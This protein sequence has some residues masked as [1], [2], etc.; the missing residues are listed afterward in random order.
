MINGDRL[1]ETFKTL[2]GIDSISKEEGALCRWLQQRLQELGFHTAVDQ[3]GSK[4]GGNTGNLIAHWRGNRAAAPLLLSAHM[5]T[6]EPGRGV[7]VQFKEGVFTSAGDTILGAD[8]K[9]ALAVMLEAISC[10]QENHIP[11]GPLELVITICEE[12]GLLGAKHLDYGQITARMGY[13]LDTRNPQAI[14]TRAPSSNRFEFRIHGKA[15]HAGAAPERGINAIALASKAIAQLNL[16]RI[17]SETTCNIGLIEG[18]LATNIV[19]DLVVIKGEARSHDEAKLEQVTAAVVSAFEQA[20][21]AGRQQSGEALPMLEKDIQSDF[22]RLFIDAGH[23]VVALAQQAAQHIGQRM[24]MA[25][26]GG[27]SDANVFAEHGIITAVLGTGME[28]VHTVNESI[29]LA[30]MLRATNLLIEIIRI[31]AERS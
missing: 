9:S 14:I 21:A 18:G 31:H 3:A 8:D 2:A 1:A 5:D 17:D 26:S 23:P 6:V 30:D 7:K 10:I 25:S 28:N 19:P 11:C 16:G 27:G 22:R 4:V 24:D 15:A 20:V 13:V 29:A 12:I